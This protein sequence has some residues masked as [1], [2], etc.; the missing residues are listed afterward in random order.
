MWLDWLGGGNRRLGGT[1]S[2]KEDLELGRTSSDDE[3]FGLDGTSREG[4]SWASENYQKIVYPDSVYWV[5]IQE[6]GGIYTLHHPASLVSYSHRNRFK[7]QLTH[8]LRW[9]G[10]LC[11]RDRWGCMLLHR[12]GHW[13]RHWVHGGHLLVLLVCG[14]L[15]LSSMVG[16]NQSINKGKAHSRHQRTASLHNTAFIFC[17]SKG[18]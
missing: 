1:I 7:N 9:D 8:L 5:L 2:V 12:C 10:R 6:D 11:F 4:R 16:I 18:L 14:G 3:Y 13:L 15:R 17:K